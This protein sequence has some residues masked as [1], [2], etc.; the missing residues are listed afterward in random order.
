MSAKKRKLDE[1][2][3][4]LR[5]EMD[6]EEIQLRRHIFLEFYS[7][8]LF[9]KDGVKLVQ[10]DE[11]SL[12]LQI[13]YEKYFQRL[14]ELEQT[15]F[16][17]AVDNEERLKAV[18][19]T[20]R[21]LEKRAREEKQRA[22]EE[23][24]RAR[25]EEQRAQ[26]EEEKEFW[27]EKIGDFLSPDQAKSIVDK[28]SIGTLKFAS[29]SFTSQLPEKVMTDVKRRWPKDERDSFTDFIQS[30]QSVQQVDAEDVIHEEIELFN[31]Y[32]VVPKDKYLDIFPT[33]V[34]K[35]QTVYAE[36][37]DWI[38]EHCEG[39]NAIVVGD[40]GIGKSTMLK[41]LFLKLRK[42]QQTVFWVMESGRW[43][44]HCNNIITTGSDAHLKK[45]LWI[46]SNV[47]LLIDGKVSDLYL[48]KMN[49]AV[50]FSSPQR[51]NYYTFLKQTFAMKL[52]LPP[53]TREEVESL[54]SDDYKAYPEMFPNGS[55]GF[56]LMLPFWRYLKAGIQ[57]INFR[58][59]K[60][61]SVLGEMVEDELS[62]SDCKSTDKEAS[63][64]EEVASDVA[65]AKPNYKNMQIYNDILA[66][67]DLDEMFQT[68]RSISAQTSKVLT[69]EQVLEYL[70]FPMPQNGDNN[71]KALIF[72]DLAS[73]SYGGLFRSVYHF[74]FLKER[75]VKQSNETQEQSRIFF[76]S[77]F[78]RM[79][80]LMDQTLMELYDKFISKG[81]HKDL[82]AAA[83]QNKVV[84]HYLNNCLSYLSET[85]R[86][87]GT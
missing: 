27:L 62:L 22:R 15:R 61:G 19:K 53:W 11:A 85:F 1:E 87:E 77:Y 9:L 25:E 52:V 40:P 59:E 74:A 81:N 14:K 86:L 70:M 68:L 55:P 47:W 65:T 4:Q 48:R 51:G 60:A 66:Y 64:D 36:L 57:K 41:I 2:E 58:N 71:L 8:D 45:A 31:G 26:K 33:R 6:E 82:I 54:F 84:K 72:K 17:I 67:S 12:A 29:T 63:T 20:R 28:L 13:K 39:T 38:L 5:R 30:L 3:N 79:K 10:S 18:D 32:W 42:Q 23:E 73:R 75:N 56:E 7:E 83:F 37:I 50:V 49:R 44:Y 80:T 16:K 35:E 69:P 76:E 21:I 78:E 34:I 24:Q 43:V 46:P